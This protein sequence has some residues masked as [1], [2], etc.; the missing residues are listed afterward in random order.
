MY[1]DE[2]VRELEA[3]EAQFPEDRKK[4]RHERYD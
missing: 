1:G 2:F 4:G 3:H